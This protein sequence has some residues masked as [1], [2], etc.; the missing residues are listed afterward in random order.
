MAPSPRGELGFYIVSD[1]SNKP[2]RVKVRAPSFNLVAAIPR[3]TIGHLVADTVAILGSLDFVLG[4]VYK[5]QL[6]GLLDDPQRLSHLVDADQ[7]AVV[8]LSLIHI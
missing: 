7:V 3:L 5:R 2:Y 4:D 8:D 1:A 6:L